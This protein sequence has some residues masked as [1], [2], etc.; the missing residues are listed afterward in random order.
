MTSFLLSLTITINLFWCYWP[1]KNYQFWVYL[2][3]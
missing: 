3:L 2:D 1:I